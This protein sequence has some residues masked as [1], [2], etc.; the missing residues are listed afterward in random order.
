MYLSVMFVFSRYSELD[1]NRNNI[2]IANF[3]DQRIVP[4]YN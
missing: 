2:F 4:P 1:V 3:L